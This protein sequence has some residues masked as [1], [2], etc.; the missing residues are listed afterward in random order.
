MARCPR[1]KRARRVGFAALLAG[2]LLG[3]AAPAA[4]Q[5]TVATNDVFDVVRLA[6]G[7]YAGLVRAQAPAYAFANSL[8]VVGEDGV[9]VV[10]TQQSER[11][12]R[13]LISLIHAL[14]PLPVRWVVNTHWHGDHVY[15]NAAYRAAWPE[16][17]FVAHRSVPA[18][19]AGAGAR[20]REEELASL[21]A[22]IAER[23]RWLEAGALPDGRALTAELRGQVQRSRD[24]RAAYLEELRAYVP[25]PATVLVEDALTLELGGRRVRLVHL[26]PAH[27]AGDVVVHVPDAGV[28][29]V[30]DLMEEALPWLEGAAPLGW[31]RALARLEGM[32]AAVLLPAHG[33]VQRGG[34]LLGAQRRFLE[35][36]GAAVREGYCAGRPREEVRAG[37]PEARLAELAAPFHRG[38]PDALAQGLTHG[39]DGIWA[40]LTEDAAPCARP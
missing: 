19:M 31:A 10:D 2:A 27:T 6:D 21:P 22:A 40:E 11:A 25:V 18:D 17:R 34:E 32:R 12:A 23:D 38:G 4:P 8:V 1:A 20:M 16:A 5:D 29:A 24:L 14:T 9:L 7:V 26:G 28:V 33:G 30:G 39:V 35:T 15:G 37:L 3:G 13:A 36:L